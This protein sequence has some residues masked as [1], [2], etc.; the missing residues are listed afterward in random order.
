MLKG[1]FL[2][3][4]HFMGQVKFR[5]H[6]FYLIFWKKT[7]AYMEKLQTVQQQEEEEKQSYGRLRLR[8]S[9]LTDS[10]VSIFNDEL[11]SVSTSDPLITVLHL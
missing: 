7:K 2:L 4:A 8:F 9:A 6:F 10:V 1:E 5:L 3:Y 11:T